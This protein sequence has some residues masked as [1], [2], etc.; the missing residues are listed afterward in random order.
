MSKLNAG[1]TDNEAATI[2]GNK[3]FAIYDILNQTSV[4]YHPMRCA[5][6]TLQLPI[7]RIFKE[8][9]MQLT[10]AKMISLLVHTSPKFGQFLK[11][12]CGKLEV[13]K[14]LDKVDAYKGSI[15]LQTD[16]KTQ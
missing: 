10:K 16:Y 1:I 7:K 9:E 2:T 5:I 15:K 14:N 6:Y 13:E 11:R 3:N 4:R 12:E 8:L